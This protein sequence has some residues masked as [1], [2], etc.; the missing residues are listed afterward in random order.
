M[1][2]LCDSCRVGNPWFVENVFKRVFFGHKNKQ[3]L[4]ERLAL[5]VSAV[6]GWTE[7]DAEKVQTRRRCFSLLLLLLLSFFSLYQTLFVMDNTTAKKV[8]PPPEEATAA[9]N[10]QEPSAAVDKVKA[11][12]T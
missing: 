7:M 2:M 11:G 9:T 10:D 12:L 5:L 6:V 8:Q 4:S 3:S 1:I